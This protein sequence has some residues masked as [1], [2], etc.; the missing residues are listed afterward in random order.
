M[1]AAAYRNGQSAN[2]NVT[3]ISKKQKTPAKGKKTGLVIGVVLVLLMLLAVAGFLV[4]WFAVKPKLQ[5]SEN[6]KLD[7][8]KSS[9]TRVYSGQM[10]LL[11]APYS[12]AYEDPSSSEFKETAKTLQD[13]LNQTLSKD[14]FLVKYYNT[15]VI[16]AFSD[17][18]FGYYWT[19]FD[20]P[21]S[22]AEMLPKLTEERILEALRR[23]I[24]QEA[25]STTQ[26]F[27]ITNITTSITDPRLAR[28]PNS[29]DC[30]FFLTAENNVQVFQSPGFPV[31]YPPQTR[32]QWQIRAPK[33]KAIVV[34]FTQFNV[35]DAC[36]TDFVF[37]YNSL[38]T[39]AANAITLNCGNRPPTNVLEVSSSGNIMLT[40]FI[41]DSEAQKPGFKALYKAVTPI[42]A[43]NCGGILTNPSGNISSPFYPSFYP[44]NVDCTWTI[45]VPAGM[46]IRVKFTMFRL[47][48]PGVNLRTCNKDYILINGTRYCGERAS[49][50][51]SSNTNSMVIQFHSDRSYTDKG[52]KAQYS[53]YDPL[54]PCPGQFTCDNGICIAKELQCDSWNDCGDMSDEKKCKCDDDHFKCANGICKARYFV[55]DQVNDCGDNS[56]EKDCS[57]AKEQVRCGDGT[58][59]PQTVV[60][61]GKKDC[62]DGSDEADCKESAGICT[63]FTYHCSNGE[64]V[65]KL[66]AECDKISDCSDGSDEVCC[67]CGERP[68]KHNRIV[69][70]IN[71]DVGEWPWQ[72]SLHY[73]DSHACGASIISDT[74]LLSAA[75]CFNTGEPSYHEVSSWKTYSGM[76]SQENIDGNVQIRDLKTIITHPDYNQLNNDNDIAV[77]ELEKPLVFSSTVHPVCL[78][79]K[80]HIFPPGMSCWVT[81]WGAIREGGQGATVLQKA[82]VKIINDTVCDSVTDGQVTSRMMCSGFLSGGVDACQGDSGGPLVCVSQEN[83]WFQ[84]GIVSWGEGCARRNKPGVYTRVTKF[85]EWIHKNTKV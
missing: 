85:R 31:Q 68:Y 73:M 49:L 53:A 18:V 24:R 26:S 54:N 84:S 52:F 58:C 50:A 64:C 56:D 20:V 75:H 13:I 17:G 2:E 4:W 61:D 6:A 36:N 62:V 82:E 15:S 27:T 21:P 38:S 3:F 63:D 40:N 1:N 28:T 12:P 42:T 41:T 44:P 48:E 71:A 7:A 16:T 60:C 67:D 77:L 11:N 30:I 19:R 39:D 29:N 14:P 43:Q 32:C 35:E 79:A 51:L 37:I 47:K 57:C 65:N 81:G 23:G 10:T 76:R 69:G 22:E 34:T 74:W 72:V 8:L 9:G 59:L 45:N 33:D 80:S 25:R 5:R 46:K 66:N 78:P 70:G 55:C 83:I